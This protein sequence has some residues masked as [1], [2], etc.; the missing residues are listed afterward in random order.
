MVSYIPSIESDSVLNRKQ[1][2]SYG[3]FK[4]ELKSVGDACI[5]ILLHILSTFYT[6]YSSDSE[7]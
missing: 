7:I 4:P 2:D 5:Y 3:Y 1:E 6:N